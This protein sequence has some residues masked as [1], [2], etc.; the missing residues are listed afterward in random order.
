MCMLTT[1]THVPPLQLREELEATV[2]GARE[3][4]AR[5][6]LD[7]FRLESE[8]EELRRGNGNASLHR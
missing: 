6:R 2:A 8:V 4:Q 3:A 7:V 5:A 1:V